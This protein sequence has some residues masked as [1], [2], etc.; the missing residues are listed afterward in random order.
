MEKLYQDFPSLPDC[1][2]L[3][4]LTTL[5]RHVDPESWAWR[6]K[7]HV[8]GLASLVQK[9]LNVNLAGKHDT[10]YTDWQARGDQ[11]TT[12]QLDCKCL[13]IDCSF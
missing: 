5:A 2:A 12:A 10:R 11:M 13:G 7:M 8:I 4:D 3:L 1:K 9:Y 6:T